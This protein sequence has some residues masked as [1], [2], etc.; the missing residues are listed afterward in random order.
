MTTKPLKRHPGLVELSRDHHH[1][2]LLS[3]KIRQGLNKSI[4]AERIKRYADHFFEIHLKS[5]FGEEESFVFPLLGNEHPLIVTALEQHENLRRL[6][7]KNTDLPATV[8]AIA[9]ALETHIRFEERELFQEMQRVVSEEKLTALTDRLQ[10]MEEKE[11]PE[12]WSDRFWEK[13]AG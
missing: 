4:E 10:K 2:L 13:Q 9:D 12:A 3:W 1:G 6:F 5:H 11:N 8:D 7:S